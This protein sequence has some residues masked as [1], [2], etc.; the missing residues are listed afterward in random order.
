MGNP[1]ATGIAFVLLGKAHCSSALDG[2]DVQIDRPS[3]QGLDDL[4][5]AIAA[6]MP[7]SDEARGEQWEQIPRIAVVGRRNVG[8]SSFCNA[9]AKE[10][11]TIVSSIPGT[12]RDSVDRPWKIYE[13]L[14]DMR[15]QRAGP[16]AAG[17]PR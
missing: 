8:K 3:R 5:E 1:G 16:K 4:E 11:R 9:L 13:E 17:S 14:A 15:P 2:P 6:L 12:T 7:M 10:E